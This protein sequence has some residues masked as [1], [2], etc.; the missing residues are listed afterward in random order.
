MA[1]YRIV[2]W[3][4]I[5]ASVEARDDDGTV[6]RPLSD[7]FQ[8][9]ID[10]AA[11]QLGLH[12]SDAYLEQWASGDPHERPGNAETVATAVVADLERRFEEFVATAFQRE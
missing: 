9:L 6:T 4:G 5:P 3:R 2:A 12:E 10:A 11:V 7:R 8:A 1:T